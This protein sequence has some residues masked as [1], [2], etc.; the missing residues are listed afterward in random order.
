M[1]EVTDSGW[2]ELA[3][4]WRNQPVP[5]VQKIAAKVRSQ[6]LRLI[7]AQ[8]FEICATIAIV[9]MAFLVR[10]LTTDAWMCGYIYVLA[11][12]AILQQYLMARSARG[13]WKRNMEN[14]RK[15]LEH[16]VRHHRQRIYRLRLRYLET[17]VIVIASIP[18]I[19]HFSKGSWRVFSTHWQLPYITSMVAAVIIVNLL[20]AFFRIR[21]FR[22]ELHEAENMRQSLS[23][24]EEENDKA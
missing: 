10:K 13:L 4:I 18:L 5:D 14:V 17:A 21:R 11:G 15:M 16:S 24:D 22:R 2:K 7:G 3:E 20:W 9:V 23:G 8:A 19:W 12:Y 6:H 1:T